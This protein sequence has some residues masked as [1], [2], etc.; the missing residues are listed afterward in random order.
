MMYLHRCSL[1]IIGIIIINHILNSFCNSNIN[2]LNNKNEFVEVH[3]TKIKKMMSHNFNMRA[4]FS[5]DINS[6]ILHHHDLN[7]DTAFIEYYN[8]MIQLM[9]EYLDQHNQFIIQIESDEDFCRRKVLVY[10]DD[11]DKCRNGIGNQFGNFFTQILVAI[12]S[13]RTFVVPRHEIP[14]CIEWVTFFPWIPLSSY[15]ESR[16]ASANCTDIKFDKDNPKPKSCTEMNSCHLFQCEAWKIWQWGDQHHNFFPLIHNVDNNPYL[17]SESKRRAEIMFP[18]TF[19]DLFR[20]SMYGVVQQ[21]TLRFTPKVL[22]LVE[23]ILSETLSI[24]DSIRISVHMRHYS[25]NNGDPSI[26]TASSDMGIFNVINSF[27]SKFSSFKCFIYLATERIETTKLVQ[28]NSV[29]YSNCTTYIISNDGNII[30]SPFVVDKDH[31]KRGFGHLPF[32]DVLL[33]Q[34]GDIFIGNKIS[35]FSM[36][37]AN[38]I[39]MT[40]LKRGLKFSPMLWDGYPYCGSTPDYWETEVL[41]KCVE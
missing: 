21:F 25:E 13:N 18:K 30:D 12:M 6:E 10:G 4:E 20:F 35:T 38:A 28:S 41:L 5:T 14:D 32:G 34:H 8:L 31:G 29:A 7:G 23:P 9:N 33:L 27:R 17:E 2:Q 39:S 16:F 24:R 19:T 1:F 40:A 36:L 22:N 15:M 3:M 37:I 26:S 11:D